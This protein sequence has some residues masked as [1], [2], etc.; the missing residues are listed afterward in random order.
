V[1]FPTFIDTDQAEARNTLD[2]ILTDEPERIICLEKDHPLG[3]TP[4]GR[5][6]IMLKWKFITAS[7]RDAVVSAQPRPIWSK[8]NFASISEEINAHDWVNEFNDLPS[9]NSCFELFLERYK[10]TCNKHIPTTTAAKNVINSPWATPLVLKAINEKRTAWWKYI[11]ASIHHKATLLDAYRIAR[12]NAFKTCKAAKMKYEEDIVERARHEPKLLYSYVRQSQSTP[13]RI[14]GLRDTAGK[15]TT[16]DNAI[17]RILNSSFQTVF[18]QEPIGELP[19][20]TDRPGTELIEIDICSMFETYD[21]ERRLEELDENKAIGPDDIHP[22][23]LKHCAAAMAKPLAM[24]F[25]RS[26]SNGRAP[27]M[28]KQANVKPIFKS[29]DKQEAINYRPISLTSIVCKV[30]ESIIREHM[31][32]HLQR[33]NLISRDQH[34]FV[35]KKSCVTNLLETYDIMSDAMEQASK[36]NWSSGLMTG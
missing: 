36:A 11:T 19:S 21:I 12:K 9:T 8:A 3:H 7:S 4:A 6:H 2:L 14:H 15:L 24:I 1:T 5:A 32:S 29:G 31:M 17:C 30:M 26:L 33:L 20:F 35:D 23:V 13:D 10:T 25:R 27:E 28:F 34:G 16:D 18:T 22:R